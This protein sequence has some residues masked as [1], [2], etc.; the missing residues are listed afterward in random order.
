VILLG[1]GGIGVVVVDILNRCGVGIDYILDT[2]IGL[3]SL[4]GVAVLP[5]ETLA[6]GGVDRDAH[7]L[8]VCIGDP[9]RRAALVER[10]PGRWGQAIDPS[11]II[12]E[13]STV[14]EGSMIFQG[15]IV[16]TNSRIGRHVIINTAA[17]VDHDCDV[18]DYVHIAPH[19]TLCGFVRVQRGAYIGAGATLLPGVTVGAGAIV[20]AGAVV[21]RDVPPGSV[22]AGVPARHLRFVDGT[23]GIEP[24]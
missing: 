5:E 9:A 18:D 2:K 1:G 22:V 15:A 19:A 13:R 3:E 11:A 24:E 7:E 23:T 14:D 16:Q 8:L 10:F 6:S 20:G 17:S 21:T 4:A 12:S